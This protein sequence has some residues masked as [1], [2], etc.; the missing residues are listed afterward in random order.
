[1]FS[2][3]P[4]SFFDE[5]QKISAVHKDHIKGGLADKLDP[6]DVNKKELKDG[7]KDEFSEHTDSKAVAKEIA[8]DHLA[9]EPNYYS[10]MKKLEKLDKGDSKQPKS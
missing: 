7:V 1:M 5:F 2:T 3:I 10:K 4:N 6:K 9:K 8:M